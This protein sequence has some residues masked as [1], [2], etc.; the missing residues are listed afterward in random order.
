MNRVHPRAWIQIGHR[1]KEFRAI[2]YSTNSA[3]HD[4]PIRQHNDVHSPPRRWAARDEQQPP[5]RMKQRIP[6]NRLPLQRIVQHI[7]LR[8]RIHRPPNNRPVV[9]PSPSFG[10]T[11][12]R[13]TA[14]TY[15]VVNVTAPRPESASLNPRVLRA[16]RSAARS[17]HGRGTPPRRTRVACCPECS[18]E[19]VRERCP[20]LP[21]RRTRS[22]RSYA[23]GFVFG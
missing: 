20:A 10:T 9:I 4:A 15:G 18:D 21:K 14:S 8:P 19:V 23:R 11:E 2:K 7:P 16:I 1:K 13:A 6:P 22:Q 5:P 3:P 12:W 17:G